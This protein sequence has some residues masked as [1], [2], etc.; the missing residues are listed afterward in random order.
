MATVS[1][2]SN[3]L[4]EY[5]TMGLL[6]E[7]MSERVYV[8]SQ[9]DKDDG[10]KD[11][12]LVV[13]F[14]GAGASS[15][16]LG[17]LTASNDIG[18]DIPVRGTVTS[19]HELWGSL[20]F[21]QRD[22][23]EHDVKKMEINFLNILPDSIDYF[24]DYMKYAVSCML[25]NG[26][27][28]ASLT[29]DGDTGGTG[30][31][32]IDR[33]DRIRVGQKLQINDSD[34]S[35]TTIYVTAIDMNTKVVTV[36]GSRAGSPLSMIAYTLAKTSV[37]YLDNGQGNSFTSIKDVLLSS[38]NG[39][40]ST[41]YGQS[42]VAYPYLQAINVSGASITATNIL[43]KIFDAYTTVRQYGKGNPNEVLMAYK[44]WGSILK[45]LELA[46]S[47][48]RTSEGSRKANVYGWDQVVLTGIKGT[49]TFTA[50]QEM[51]ESYMAIIDWRAFK[52]HSNGGFRKRVAPDG[53]SYFEIRNT[54]GYQY[55]VDI[56][57]FGEL[58]C[59]R[60]SYCGIIYGISY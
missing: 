27:I 6:R 18:Q 33:P 9:M 56:C 31:L 60:P 30:L 36:S 38:V 58:V 17:G 1:N 3:M 59:S 4:N 29:A 49:L 35:P 54:T 57:L 23:Y 22:L 53:K 28:V 45:L 32:T 25:T 26:A 51:D 46:K 50:V 10:W 2:F 24:M 21:N 43:D 15:L 37:L 13:P 40:S 20:I 41:L 52:F 39:G 47:P 12:N 11:Q 42:K 48:F 16:S 55:I 19:P 5:L 44:H 34:V 8:Y 7:E 14:M